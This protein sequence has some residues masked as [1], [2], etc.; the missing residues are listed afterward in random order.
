MSFFF[1]LFVFLQ[2]NILAELVI[3]TNVIRITFIFFLFF[4]S[5]SYVFSLPCLRDVS[6]ETKR[7]LN[8]KMEHFS[9]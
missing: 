7:V 5:F 2:L 6:K 3:F 4:S 8:I 1:C 9:D